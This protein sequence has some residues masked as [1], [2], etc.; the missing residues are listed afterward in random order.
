MKHKILQ[1]DSNLQPYSWDFDLRA[2]QYKKTLSALLKDGMTLSDFA[3]GHEYFG[4]HKTDAGWFTGNGR[5]ERKKCTSP[6]IF[7]VGI[8]RLTP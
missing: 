3:N 7:A 6:A 5:P 2:Q 1:Y 8:G 4:F